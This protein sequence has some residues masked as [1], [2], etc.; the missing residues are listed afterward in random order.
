MKMGLGLV[1]PAT[2]RDRD[3]TLLVVT[4]TSPPLPPS[5]PVKYQLFSHIIIT[6]RLMVGHQPQ[7][8]ALTAGNVQEVSI[9]NI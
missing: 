6:P 5:A 7:P 8:A 3:E 2:S 9:I 4:Q 1:G